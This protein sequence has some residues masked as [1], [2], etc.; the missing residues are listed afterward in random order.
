LPNLDARI[1]GL[2]VA[3][4]FVPARS[5]DV[6]LERLRIHSVAVQTAADR[7][8]AEIDYRDRDE[9]LAAAL[10]HDIGKLPLMTIDS[11]Y[12][13]QLRARQRTPEQRL[14]DEHR[15]FGLDHAVLGG[16]LLRRWGLPNRL[17][18]IVERHHAQD[19]GLEAKV[20]GLGDMLV[21]HVHGATVE[22][23]SLL[24]LSYAIGLDPKRLRSVIYQLAA[25]AAV[26]QRED[27][28]SP[29][30]LKETDALRGLAE[31]KTY[32]Q[33]AADMGISTSTVRTHMHNTY[34]KL[35]VID[36]AQA[37]LL[38]TERGWL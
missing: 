27:E 22:A 24:R 17:A 33:I 8:L 30:S 3:D 2:P 11:R 23:A 28:P 5:E 15:Q 20:V 9:L 25:G 14:H 6:E 36:R 4:M 31:G 19:G 13:E 12:R 1:S 32:G 7:I 34:K 10:L 26:R 16:L 29:L 37:V 21:H 38:A 35:D 18:A